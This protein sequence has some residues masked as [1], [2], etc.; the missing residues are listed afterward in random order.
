MSLQGPLPAPSDYGLPLLGKGGR[1]GG[2][3][4][5]GISPQYAK[6]NH[7]SPPSFSPLSYH[8]KSYMFTSEAAPSL[9]PVIKTVL[10][11]RASLCN[12]RKWKCVRTRVRCRE[13]ERGRER[14][15]KE[16]DSP[17]ASDKRD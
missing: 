14:S 5:P 7:S 17:R 12:R 10:C 15:G 2:G 9:E 1:A 6:K 3:G 16:D 4:L 8:S 11:H 13:M